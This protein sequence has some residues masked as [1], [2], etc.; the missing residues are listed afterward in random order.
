MQTWTAEEV[1]AFLDY[2]RQADERLYALWVLAATTGMRRGELLG[3]RWADLDLDAARVAIRRTVISVGYE[4]CESEPKTKKGR[5]TIDIDPTTVAALRAHRARQA[6]ERLAWGPAYEDS[7]R[8]FAR[9]NGSVLH[10]ER[11]SQ[12][13]KKHVRNAG[14]PAI[15]FHDVRHTHATLGLA[16]GVPPKVMSERL[17]HSTVAFTLDLYTHAVP[18]LQQQAANQVAALIF[19]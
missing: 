19:G 15:R 10:P 7:G 9:E 16:A 4:V 1:R 11:V 18:A 2:V 14:L 8:L 5:R 12:L 17:G 13:F 3:L 6:E